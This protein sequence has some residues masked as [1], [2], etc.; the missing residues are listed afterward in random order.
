MATYGTRLNFRLVNNR[1]SQVMR[2]LVDQGSL[3]D[4]KTLMT[5]ILANVTAIDTYIQ[6]ASTIDDLP[7]D[8]T[9]TGSSDDALL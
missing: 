9:L 7:E 4:A 3:A 8:Q 1:F 2:L 5:T 6:A